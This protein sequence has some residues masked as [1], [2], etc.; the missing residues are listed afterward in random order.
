[1]STEALQSIL[2]QLKDEDTRWEGIFELKSLDYPTLGEELVVLLNEPEWVIRWCVAEKL[3]DMG[4]VPAAQSLVDRLSDDDAHVRKNVIK[5][6]YKLGVKTIPFLVPQFAHPNPMIRKYVSSLLIK[7]GKP[8]LP[9]LPEVLPNQNWIVSN[10]IVELMWK[11]GGVESEVYLIRQLTNTKV[12]KNVINLLG[13]IPSNRCVRAL[14]KAYQFPPLKRMIIHTFNR[15]G[16]EETYPKLIETMF[17]AEPKIAQL[18]RAMVIKI[19]EPAVPFLLLALQAHPQSKELFVKLIMKISPKSKALLNRAVDDDP[20]VNFFVNQLK[21]RLGPD[22]T[23]TS[24]S[25]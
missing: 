6:L 19:G 17:D 25:S 3:G 23:T 16:K 22:K 15:I 2:V 18:S 11:I 9:H 7:F 1:M 14:I 5:A 8:V 12:Q 20:Q 10:R 13:F 24:P 4:Y 21:S